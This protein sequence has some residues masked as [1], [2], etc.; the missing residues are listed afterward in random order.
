MT[1]VSSQHDTQDH[2]RNRN[3]HHDLQRL[4]QAPLNIM[5]GW[6]DLWQGYAQAMQAS[7]N[8]LGHT[9]GRATDDLTKTMFTMRHDIRNIEERQEQQ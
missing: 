9:M 6:I 3:L 2:N 7:Y 8:L 5:S 4:S 1:D